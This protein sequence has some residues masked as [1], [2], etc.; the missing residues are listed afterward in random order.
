VDAPPLPAQG[1]Y[2]P[3]YGEW[4]GRRWSELPISG[5]IVGAPSDLDGGQHLLLFYRKDCEHCHALMEAF[6]VGELAVP[7]T[8]VAVPER[9]GF[10]TEG[11]QPFPCDE[12]SIAEL[13]AGVDWFLKTPVLVRLED[14]LVRCAAE[15][16][17]E[18]PACLAM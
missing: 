5:W 17:P 16:A 7:T 18:E 15:V 13:P 10:P 1:F 4:L 2:L 6:F 14:G 8:A 11:L 3:E 9:S 12:C